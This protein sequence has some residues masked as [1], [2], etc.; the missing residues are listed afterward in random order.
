[1]MSDNLLWIEILNIYGIAEVCIVGTAF[2]QQTGKTF[3]QYLADY[4]N[5]IYEEPI[6]RHYPKE[7]PIF[8]T[9]IIIH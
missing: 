6:N 2:K 3:T 8:L 7:M 4:K 1:M 5:G 9:V